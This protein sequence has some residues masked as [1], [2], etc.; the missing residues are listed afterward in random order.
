M[1]NIVHGKYSIS[2]IKIEFQTSYIIFTDI[3]IYIYTLIKYHNTILSNNIHEKLHNTPCQLPPFVSSYSFLS[4]PPTGKLHVDREIHH[5]STCLE[6]RKTGRR[7][8]EKQQMGVPIASVFRWN[9]HVLSW[10]VTSDPFQTL[11]HVSRHI[12]PSQH[13]ITPEVSFFELQLGSAWHAR[14]VASSFYKKNNHMRD[15]QVYIY[16]YIYE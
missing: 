1:S 12:I 5:L 11:S 7:R 2:L 10:P 9:W 13:I 16:I 14:N 15:F 4:A 8:C 3:Y 6:G